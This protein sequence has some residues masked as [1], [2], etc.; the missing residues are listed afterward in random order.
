MLLTMVLC[1][2]FTVA[3]CLCNATA[4][5]LLYSSINRIVFIEVALNL[6]DFN[7]FLILFPS[8]QK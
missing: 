6:R 7:Y 4:M 2:Y 8:L 5:G 1:I 3:L